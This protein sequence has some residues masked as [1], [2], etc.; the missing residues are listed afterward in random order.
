MSTEPGG[1]LQ[2]TDLDFLDNQPRVYPTIS[3]T[4]SVAKEGATILNFWASQNWDKDFISSVAAILKTCA[5]EDVK[6][7]HYIDNCFSNPELHPIL[8]EW[9]R[10]SVPAILRA[11]TTR[12][13][14]N[15][16]EGEEFIGEYERKIEVMGKM[17]TVFPIPITTLTARKI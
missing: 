3:P 1:F 17:G 13:G 9:H 8:L 12:M 15:G 5:V 14:K 4:L 7:K 11:M 16:E 6:I 10:I 2:W